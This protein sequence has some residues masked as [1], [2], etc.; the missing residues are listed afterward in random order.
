MVIP[1]RGFFDGMFT[2]IITHIGEITEISMNRLIVKTKKDFTLK[3]SK[4]GSICL[5]G[6]CLT[7]AGLTKS[8]FTADVMP[9]TK[10][11]TNL[12]EAKV[13]DSVNLELPAT[14]SSFLSGHIIQGHVDGVAKLEEIRKVENSHI[15]KFSV[16]KNLSKYLVEK[17]SVAI[18]GIS[19]TVI[20]SGRDYF[21]VGIIPYTWENTMLHRVKVGDRFN[22]E[23]DILAKY[24][25]RLTK[26]L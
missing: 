11:K 18:N 4:G 2:G 5:N 17:G 23:V 22:I 16:P 12:G 15:L 26:K 7:L 3:L 25:E 8:G 20:K 14:P 24:L 6:V 21:T 13:G 1:E 9:E 19:L 10:Q